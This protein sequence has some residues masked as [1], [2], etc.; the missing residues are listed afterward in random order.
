MAHFCTLLNGHH[1]LDVTVYV[2]GFVAAG[3]FVGGVGVNVSVSVVDENCYRKRSWRARTIGAGSAND[4]SVDVQVTNPLSDGV[5]LPG[6][7]SEWRAN[8]IKE[9]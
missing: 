6:G 7:I 8:V 1:L 4:G 5:G 2:V 3:I 9:I